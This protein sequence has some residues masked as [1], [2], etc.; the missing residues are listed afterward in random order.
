MIH[1]LS[2]EFAAGKYQNIRKMQRLS[3]GV[4]KGGKRI[5]WKKGRK[6]TRVRSGR[7]RQNS[8]CGWNGLI[9]EHKFPNKWYR[10]ESV[11]RM[12]ICITALVKSDSFYTW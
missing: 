8:N 6:G 2:L 11:I 12:Q 9:F 7:A 5:Y 10:W 3:E 4:T 1:R